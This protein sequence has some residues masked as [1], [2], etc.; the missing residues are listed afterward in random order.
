MWMNDRTMAPGP[1]PVPEESR[2]EQARSQPYHRSKTFSDVIQSV[3]TNIQTILGVEWPVLLVASSGTGAMEMAASNIV[4]PGDTVIVIEAGKFGERWTN[5]LEKH[6]I[7]V[8][9]HTVE[10]G[11]TASPAK[12]AHRLQENSDIR[13]VFSTHVETSTLTTHPIQEIGSIVADYEDCIFVVDAISSI[14]AEPFHPSEWNVDVIVGGSQK[15]LMT[16]PGISFVSLNEVAETR[17]RRSNRSGLYFDVPTALKRLRNDSQ[18]PWTPPRSLLQSMNTSLGMILDE[19][20][21][22]TQERHRILAHVCRD[23]V[24]AM[25]LDLF[26]ENPSVV[27]TAV[28][29]P[30]RVDG[31]TVREVM[32][33]ELSMYVPGGQRQL[34]GKILRIGHLGHVDFFDI[35]SVLSAFEYALCE[36]N[37]IQ[38]PGIALG[39]A[40]RRFRDESA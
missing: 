31:K 27:G 39:A 19:G 36:E 18:T 6:D 3:T 17:A 1:T 40:Q 22:S 8:L 5:I 25:K 32:K 38:E 29:L 4:S 28:E 35:L 34:E 33:D 16:P 30:S 7:Q 14:G 9:S 24:R 13:A 37:Y 2:L 15:G 26:S 12:I 23:A 20:I 10:W 11:R 21:E